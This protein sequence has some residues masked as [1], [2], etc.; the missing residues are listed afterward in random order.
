VVLVHFY[1]FTYFQLFEMPG[2]LWCIDVKYAITV[3]CCILQNLAS[4]SLP[5]FHNLYINKKLKQ[6]NLNRPIIVHYQK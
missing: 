6:C 4:V 5:D 3:A 2:P 1:G